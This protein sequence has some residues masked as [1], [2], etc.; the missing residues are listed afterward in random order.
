[1]SDPT[2]SLASLK[3]ASRWLHSFA[4][5]VASQ[6]GEDGILAKTLSLLP[7]TN[8][9]CVEFGAWDGQ[10]LS[11][12]FNLVHAHSYT[13]VLIEADLNKYE[14]LC[15]T[16][17][18]PDRAIFINK[19]VGWSG[20]DSLDQI[21]AFYP[22]PRDFDLLS[23]DIDGN[24]H[25]VWSATRT[26]RP[27]LVL[28]EYNPTIANGIEFVQRNDFHCSQ[29]NSATS[30]VQLGKQK[31]YELI[32]VTRLNLLFVDSKYYSL[33]NIPDNSLEVIRDDTE[34]GQIFFGYDGTV[35]LLQGKSV[36]QCLLPWH[37]CR[38]SQRRV[39][40]LP[41]LLR[42]YPPTYNRIQRWAFA[43]LSVFN[44]MWTDPRAALRKL[45]R[46][47]RPSS[48]E[49]ARQPDRNRQ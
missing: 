37:G 26:Y 36:G 1:M 30:L 19:C 47:A 45:K 8:R 4:S 29:G 18:H 42:R 44:V 22:V 3:R 6:T 13:A 9:W 12:T 38:L 24:D 27:K 10:H 11:N 21:L 20:E 23:V 17:P 31:G 34:V 32:A 33:F 16:Y 5:D 40:V 14:D 49:G 28:I 41:A 15:S 2:P 7:D 48:A 43:L 25:H 46:Y 39:Q 35:F